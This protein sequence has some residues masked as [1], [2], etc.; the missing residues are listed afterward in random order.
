MPLADYKPPTKKL[1]F[2]GGDFNVRAISLT[3]ISVIIEA[4]EYQIDRIYQK[5]Q[6]KTGQQITAELVG[7][8]FMDTIREAPVLVSH[9]IAIAADERDA[10]GDLLL[11]VAGSLPMTVQVE[12]LQAIGELT[13][14][15][16]ASVKKFG[17]D[18]M[19]LIRGIL[20]PEQQRA[21]AAA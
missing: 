11:N 2:P 21:L 20:P 14:T 1:S 3:D 17:A 8:V 15:D 6:T 16:L 13:F 12:A 10:N 4:H 19:K 7:D 5:V 18:V 9:I